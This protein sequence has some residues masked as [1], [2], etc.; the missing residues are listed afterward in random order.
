MLGMLR[1]YSYAIFFVDAQQIPYSHCLTYFD[2][3]IL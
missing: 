1:L 2:K 3:K